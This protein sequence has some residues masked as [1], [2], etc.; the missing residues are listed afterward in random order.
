MKLEIV[1]LMCVVAALPCFALVQNG[2]CTEK[3]G[4][5]GNS[6]RIGIASFTKCSLLVTDSDGRLELPCRFL[7]EDETHGGKCEDVVLSS[8]LTEKR[9]RLNGI[10]E[11]WMNRTYIVSDTHTKIG[12]LQIEKEEDPIDVI[13]ILKE[14]GIAG[15]GEKDYVLYR[16]EYEKYFRYL[17]SD[18]NDPD[19]WRAR[20][21][22][23][24]IDYRIV[25]LCACGDQFVVTNLHDKSSNF[26]KTILMYS[27]DSEGYMLKQIILSGDYIYRGGE[28]RSDPASAEMRRMFKSSRSVMSESG[29]GIMEIGRGVLDCGKAL[30]YKVYKQ[31]SNEC[32]RIELAVDGKTCNS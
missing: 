30:E 23:N 32:F 27:K 25:P 26:Q 1:M 6:N 31:T 24:N 11:H 8:V 15:G 7:L 13:Y 18:A 12:P 29:D 14:S 19:F 28:F 21:C 2:G 20:L 3:P 16:K 22:R 4:Y 17:R 5:V 9:S 10:P